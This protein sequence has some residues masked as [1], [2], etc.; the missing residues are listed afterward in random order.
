MC[1]THFSIN[2]YEFSGRAIWDHEYP[3]GQF[4][5]AFRVLIVEVTGAGVVDHRMG[6]RVTAR[7]GYF[8]AAWEEGQSDAC[9]ALSYDTLADLVAA[10]DGRKGPSWAH[11]RAAVISAVR[12]LF[13]DTVG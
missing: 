12:R 5:P 10:Q 2:K 3:R 11:I 8:L 9:F 13:G 1:E 6:G 7:G 4:G